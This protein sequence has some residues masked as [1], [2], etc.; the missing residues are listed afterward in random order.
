MGRTIPVTD[1]VTSRDKIKLK[2]K[3]LFV[4]PARVNQKATSQ[5]LSVRFWLVQRI[6]SFRPYLT[7]MH[8]GTITLVSG[9]VITTP[10][11]QAFQVSAHPVTPIL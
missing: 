8:H 4:I 6:R 3:S 5:C 10:S 11:K 1:R 7:Q 9:R 2:Y